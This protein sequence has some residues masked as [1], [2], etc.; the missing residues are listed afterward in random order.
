MRKILLAAALLC[1]TTAPAVAATLIDTG[2]SA[3]PTIARPVNNTT[4]LFAQFDLAAASTIESIETFGRTVTS[5][6][7][8]FSIFADAANAPGAL[9]FSDTVN[10]VQS[11]KLKWDGISGLAWGLAQGTYWVSVGQAAPGFTAYVLGTAP[12]PLGLEGSLK[13]QG[14]IQTNGVDLSWRIGGTAVPEPATWI[15]MIGGFAL[16]GAALRRRSRPANKTLASA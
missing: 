3:A 4:D 15:S 5:G 8:Q 10:L 14:F 7:A 1:S 2:V 12:S 9:L 16:V 6:L 13:P 11:G